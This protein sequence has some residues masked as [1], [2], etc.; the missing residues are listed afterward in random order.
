[1]VSI[2]KNELYKLFHSRRIY[3]FSGIMLVTLIGFAIIINSIS[4]SEL[5]TTDMIDEMKGINFPLQFLST[6]SDLLLPVFVVLIMTFFVSDEYESGT[7]KLPILQGFRRESIIIAKTLISIFFSFLMVAFVYLAANMVSLGL[8]GTKSYTADGLLSITKI[9]LL[10][11][12]P[13]IALVTFTM[14]LSLLVKNSGLVIGIL[15]AI[16]VFSSLIGS[17]FP[18]VSKYMFTYHL[19]AFAQITDSYL[20][21]ILTCTV[22][23][24]IFLMSALFTF[25]KMEIHK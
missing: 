4:P 5:I 8:W 9:F 15:I 7:L 11:V 20:N 3:I 19:K 14:L 23:A 18:E 24:I 13:I 25:N 10:S 16:L 21:G 6:I 12:I 1:M 22:S 2:F 17:M